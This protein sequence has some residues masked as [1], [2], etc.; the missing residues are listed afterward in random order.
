MPADPDNSEV[1]GEVKLIFDEG[2]TVP[3]AFLH[4]QSML[5]SCK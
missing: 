3:G 4:A 5:R 1:D 2:K